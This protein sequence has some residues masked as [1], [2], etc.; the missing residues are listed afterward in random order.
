MSRDPALGKFALLQVARLLGAVLALAGIVV[1]G[2]QRSE[3]AQ[4]PIVAGYALFMAGLALFFALPL[5][6][7]RHWKGKTKA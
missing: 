4:V 2:G 6:L 1:L 3:L 7:A 5:A